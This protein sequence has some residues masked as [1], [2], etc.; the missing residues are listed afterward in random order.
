MYIIEIQTLQDNSLY[1]IIYHNWNSFI[2]FFRTNKDIDR[3]KFR[4]SS[5]QSH[6]LWGYITLYHDKVLTHKFSLCIP[7]NTYTATHSANSEKFV[8]KVSCRLLPWLFTR[9]FC[10]YQNCVCVFRRCLCD[11]FGPKSQI[12][13]RYIS[14]AAWRE[15]PFT[16]N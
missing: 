7:C 9:I 13:T 8:L 3:Y 15:E 16:T 14:V 10:W 2:V 6:I 12:S 11:I 1:V 4:S 5:Y